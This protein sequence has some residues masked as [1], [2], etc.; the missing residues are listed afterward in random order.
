MTEATALLG[1]GLYT[2]PEAA[3]LSRVRAERIRRW[4]LGYSYRD[5]KGGERPSPPVWAREIA[6]A[7][8]LVVTFRDLLE[9]RFVDAF[10]RHN[11]SWKVIR[12][13]AEKAAEIYQTSHPFSTKRFR[14]DGRHIFADVAQASGDD[15]L[16]DLFN[17]QFAFKQIVEPFLMRGFE[18]SADAKR[19]VRWWPSG[20]RKRVVLDPMRSF[21]KPIISDRGIPTVTLA[22]SYK[23][24]ES[25]ERVARW[26]ETDVAS[27]V[28]AVQYEESLAA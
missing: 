23:A 21:G 26:F 25:F 12:R 7:D 27:V 5:D 14:T 17:S 18:F 15:S 2:V 9:I 20:F 11:I 10:R 16:L 4:M 6:D 28:A 13:S 1:V 3:R 8:G 24:E 22:A 19:V